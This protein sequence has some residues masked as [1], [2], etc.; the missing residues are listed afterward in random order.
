MRSKAESIAARLSAATGNTVA[1]QETP[2]G[3]RLEVTVPNGLD[4][5]QRSFLLAALADADSYGHER[6]VDTDYV[7]AMIHEGDQ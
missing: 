4:G 6:T 3:V 5:Q 1:S 7:W 2:D